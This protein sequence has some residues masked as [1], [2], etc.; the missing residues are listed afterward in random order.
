MLVQFL[1][2]PQ[3]GGLTYTEQK[4]HFA[5]WCM[6]SAPLMLGNDPRSM[7]KATLSILTNPELLAISQ[8]PLAKQ[9]KKVNK[10][11]CG[12]ALA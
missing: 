4:T 11:A 1:V 6:L 5:L 8:D 12:P 9:A 2:S 7:T 10:L 3:V